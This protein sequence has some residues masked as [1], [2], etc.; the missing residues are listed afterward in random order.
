VFVFVLI[1]TAGVALARNHQLYGGVLPVAGQASAAPANQTV[2]NNITVS[3]EVI[4]LGSTLQAN[5]QVSTASG[6]LANAS[7]ALHIGDL[8]VAHAQ[9]DQK[10]EYAFAV[11]VGAYYFPAAFSNGAVIY[12]VVEPRDSSF[13]STPSAATN[14]PVDLLPLI[15]IVVLVIG[16][17]GLGLYWYTRRLKA[18]SAA[19]AGKP[20]KRSEESVVALYAR[21]L[22]AKASTW[23]ERPMVA[24]EKSAEKTLRVTSPQQAYES[25]G[26]PLTTPPLAAELTE[27]ASPIESE[28]VPVKLS[29]GAVV[30]EEKSAEKTLRVTSPQQAYESIGPPLTTPP[31][32]AELTEEASPIESEPERETP[33]RSVKGVAVGE[34]AM[35]AEHL[36]KKF[37]DLTIVDDLNLE[38][39]HG[40][41]FGFLGPN[42]AGKTTS[43]KMMTGLLQPTSGRVL[44]NGAELVSMQKRKIGICP[45]ELV[46]WEAL[47]CR[48]NLTFMGKMYGVEKRVLENRVDELLDYLSLTDKADQAA[49]KLS[50]GMKRRL[51][52]AL[53]VVHHP[54]IVFLDEPSAGLDP[55][56]RQLLWDFIRGL[57]DKEGKTVIL[58]THVMEEADALSD[59]VAIIDHGKLLLLDTPDALKKTMGKGDVVELQLEDI[60]MNNAIVQRVSTLDGIE[61][62]Y[63]LKDRVAVRALNAPSKLPELISVIEGVGGSVCDVTIR[64][65]T[66]EDVFI[67]LTG[68]ALRE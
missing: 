53:S 63:E 3:S 40:E 14:L 56:T 4:S 54:E 39:K 35:K 34:S 49:S 23:S 13:I 15:I 18:T 51:N 65:N 21:R 31:L 1:V 57:R 44:F 5:G 33:Q 36:T 52:I 27:E 67:Y 37:G 45:Q 10:G 28:P 62:A 32:A 68:R 48:E 50:G 47:T 26:P 8:T 58:T 55:Q 38:I 22:K 7:V 9:T 60:A 43:I 42:G 30:A 29:D 20:L 12:T 64:G 46:L 19:R 6:P 2:A 41:V 25:I 11:P 16:A 61:E 17:I 66:L 24:E 59:R